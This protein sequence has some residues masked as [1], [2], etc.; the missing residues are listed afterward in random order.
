[1]KVI[2][3]GAGPAGLAATYKLKKEGADVQAFESTDKPGGRAQGMEKDGF[4]FDM[5][6]Q[7]LGKH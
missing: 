3:V 6:A 5:G 2:V 7:F 4:V 1:M